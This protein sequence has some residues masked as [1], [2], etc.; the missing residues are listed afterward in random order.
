MFP[1]STEN[2]LVTHIRPNP[3]LYG[4]FWICVTLVFSIAISGNM[5]NYFQTAN[6]SHY[7]WR[8]D[9]HLISYAATSIFLYAWLLPLVLWGTLKWTTSTRNTEEE[10]IEVNYDTFLFFPFFWSYFLPRTL[11]NT[12]EEIFFFPVLRISGTFR[13]HMLIRIFFN[14]LH[15]SCIFVDDTNQLVTVDF[16][17]N[18]Y[19]F[20]WRCIASFIVPCHLR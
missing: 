2:Y 15:S 17:D 12:I 4:P 16:S 14:H 8:Y 3:D 9:F 5:A 13:A 20:V 18:S 6:S 19:I 7:H 11:G 10:L 1:H